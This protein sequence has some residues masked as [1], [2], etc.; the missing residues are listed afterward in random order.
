MFGHAGA[1]IVG[2]FFVVEFDWEIVVKLGAARVGE[3]V[4][5]GTTAPFEPMPGRAMK[6]WAQ[7]PCPHDT[8]GAWM[9][10]AEEARRYVLG[11]AAA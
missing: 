8:I 5:A 11:A 3:L 4:A 9:A 2:R 7:A 1:K 10:L 6:D